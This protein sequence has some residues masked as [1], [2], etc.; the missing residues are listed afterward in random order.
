ME[1]HKEI[2]KDEEDNNEAR[3]LILSVVQQE[4]KG[5]KIPP[6]PNANPPKGPSALQCIM[7]NHASKGNA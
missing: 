5:L 7:K 4:K 1:Y 2:N 6:K 3:G